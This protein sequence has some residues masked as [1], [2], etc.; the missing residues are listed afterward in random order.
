MLVN[1][2][3]EAEQAEEA[4]SLSPLWESQLEEESMLVLILYR[5][6]HLHRFAGP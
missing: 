4:H 5:L 3:Q 1:L 2:H 6:S